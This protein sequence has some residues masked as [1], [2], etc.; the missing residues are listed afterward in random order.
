M[1]EFAI[2]IIRVQQDDFPAARAAFERALMENLP[3]HWAHVRL[4][5]SALG[6]HDTASALRDLDE[7]IQ[8][9]GSSCMRLATIRSV[10]ARSGPSP[11]SVR[12]LGIR[13]ERS[14]VPPGRG[15]SA[16]H[17][18]DPQLRRRRHTPG[19]IETVSDTTLRS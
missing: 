5:G 11:Y 1:L 7:A 13:R 10:R 16:T 14:G 2:G 19:S 18:T 6:L 4:A 8:L 17:R 15:T 9:E 12:H 3:F